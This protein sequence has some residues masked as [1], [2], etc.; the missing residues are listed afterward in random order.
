MDDESKRL[1]NSHEIM[2]S[3]AV[4]TS[5]SV[6]VADMAVVVSPRKVRVKVPPVAEHVIVWTSSTCPPVHGSSPLGHGTALDIYYSISLINLMDLVFFTNLLSSH[7]LYSV[8]V[9]LA[10]RRIYYTNILESC[11]LPMC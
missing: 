7:S 9:C 11:L 1:I 3:R 8:N 2:S 4:L 5:S 6:A 10:Y